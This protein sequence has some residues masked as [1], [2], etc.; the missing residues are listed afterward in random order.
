MHQNSRTYG[1][2]IMHSSKVILICSGNAASDDLLFVFSQESFKYTPNDYIY[3]VSST[4]SESPKLSQVSCSVS[5]II[6]QF[7]KGAMQMF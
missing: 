1:T 5:V 6:L 3:S 7:W 4:A 2:N